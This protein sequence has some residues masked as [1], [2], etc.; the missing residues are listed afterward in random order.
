[1]AVSLSLKFGENDC[2]LLH[3]YCDILENDIDKL[4]T[5]PTSIIFHTCLIKK[6]LTCG[7]SSS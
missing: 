1:M 4:S 6:H 2:F 5:F 3:I 7:A